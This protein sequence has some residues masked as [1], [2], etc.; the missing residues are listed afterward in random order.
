MEVIIINHIE[1]KMSFKNL[2]KFAMPSIIMMIFL[3]SYTIIDGFFV[4]RY[5]GSEALAA[6]NITY[7]LTGLMLA[8]GIMFSTGGSALVGK[9]LGEGENQRAREC[10]TLISLVSV[11]IAVIL[12][13]IIIIFLHP[14]LILLGSDNATY[15]FGY[16]YI[17]IILIFSPAAALQLLTQSFMVVDSRPRLGLALTIAA[18]IANMILDYVFMGPCNM[19]ITGAAWATITGYMITAIGGLIYFS[20]SKKSLYIVKPKLKLSWLAQSM[21]N[22]SSEMVTN[23]SSAIIT[24]L[25]NIFMLYLLGN[26]GVAAITVILYAQFVMLSF[27]IGYSMGVAPVFSYHFGAGNKEY[28]KDIR[29]KSYTFLAIASIIVCIVSMLSAKLTGELFSNGD[30]EIKE[31]IIRGTYLF[32]INYLFS[33]INV[34]NSSLFTALNDGKTSALISFMRTFIFIIIFMFAMTAI[35]K[36]DGLFLSIPFAELTT[37]LVTLAFFKRQYHKRELIMNTPKEK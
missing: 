7:P 34:F 28:I 10:F 37:L 20:T 1:N 33:G 23:L 31:L 3:S 8:I 11:L 36:V 35:L 15:Q 21:L 5:V 30:I 17:L 24:L 16:D 18:G 25:F 12:P 19:G 2:I 9:L 29:N 27:F 13:L 4:T 26:K 32:S 22:G 6:L 14:I